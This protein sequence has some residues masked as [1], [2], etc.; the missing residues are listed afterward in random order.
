MS[1]LPQIPTEIN[2][3]CNEQL[4]TTMVK[5]KW[6]D[7]VI[8]WKHFPR[9]YWPFVRGIHRSP[10]NSPHK[11]QWRGAFDVFFDLRLN[12]SLS[13]QSWGWWFE[14]PSRSLW[15]HCNDWGMFHEHS[16]YWTRSGI[17][18]N[19]KECF[20]SFKTFL[21]FLSEKQINK[22]HT[23]SGGIY[24]RT[25]KNSLR[26]SKNL[27]QSL[28]PDDSW[29]DSW[30]CDRG[31]CVNHSNRWPGILMDG[32]TDHDGDRRLN[33]DIYDHIL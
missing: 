3:Y 14:T 10:V 30:Q 29:P 6:H 7:D 26:R 23:E 15:R 24:P 11:G 28:V 4:R 21:M 25:G 19:H 20:E 8:K 32:W 18:R 33:R 12:K 22:N 5:A 27:Q 16:T 1:S 2:G 13:N 9:Y 31:S 17:T